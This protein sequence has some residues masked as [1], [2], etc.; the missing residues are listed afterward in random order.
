MFEHPARG[1][2][3][4]RRLLDEVEVEGFFK[5]LSEGLDGGVAPDEMRD[6][7]RSAVDGSTDAG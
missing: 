4:V 7:I 3:H 6:Y 5:A 2:K 1:E